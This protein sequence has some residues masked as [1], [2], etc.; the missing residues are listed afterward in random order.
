MHAICR[1][2]TRRGHEV[3][4]VCIGPGRPGD[5]QGV[6]VHVC[7][8]SSRQRRLYE[9]ADVVLTHLERTRDA[10][11]LSQAA[12]KP[13]V[14]VVHNDTQLAAHHVRPEHAD[15]VVF[16]SRWVQEAASWPGRQM[17]LYPP[18]S[19]DE[20]RATPGDAITLINLT[21][22]KGA[23]L[24]YELAQ[25]MPDRRFIGV[26]GG[27]GR[28]IV[29]DILPPNVTILPNTPDIRS[30]YQRTRI[31]LMPSSYESWGR[32]AIEAAASGI[33][34]VANPTPG[35][36]E[37]LG[38][39]GLFADRGDPEAWVAILRSME[40]PEIY[41]RQ[42]ELVRARCRELDP[43]T[44]LDELEQALLSLPGQPESPMRVD[45]VASQRHYVDHLAPIWSALPEH[46]RGAFLVQ[47]DVAGHAQTRS[48][49][50][51]EFRNDVELLALL[52]R[53]SGPVVTAGYGDLKLADRSRRPQVFT[54]HGAGQ[55]YLPF[56]HPAYA[57]GTDARGRLQLYLAPNDYAET[58]HRMRHPG[59]PVE[60]IGCPKLD[61]WHKHARKPVG[62]PVVA[63]SFHWDCQVV[64]ETRTAWPHFRSALPELARRYQ[65]LGH[66]H[67]RIIEQLAPEYRRLGIEV[68]HDFEEVLERA[69]I[70]VCDNSSTLFE[71]AATGRPVVLLNAPWYRRDVHHGLRFWDAAE[72]GVQCDHP[73]TLPDAVEEAIRD[74][75]DRRRLREEVVARVYPV[76][77]GTA[78]GRAAR[79]LL[80]AMNRIRAHRKAPAPMEMHEQEVKVLREMTAIKS[81]AGTVEL[82]SGDGWIEHT[83]MVRKGTPFRV[84]DAKAQVYEKTSLAKPRF[85]GPSEIKPPGPSETKGQEQPGA[86]GEPPGSGGKPGASPDENSNHLGG[87]PT[88][89]T[90]SEDDWPKHTGGGYY[91]LSNGKKVKGKEEGLAAQAALR[92]GSGGTQ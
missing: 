50:P 10:A 9:W 83:G 43:T 1:D 36:R 67:P 12:G 52:R 20:Y 45:F 53:G 44:Q 77:D 71:F 85:P 76:R 11:R 42:S 22:Q 81:F 59:I 92:G 65:V 86:Q 6:M 2:M 13:L 5:F 90:T 80:G 37:A 33:P 4:V 69:D 19:A 48:V 34:T 87:D 49:A 39:S 74:S 41:D 91:L 30:V 57:G 61:A 68:V 75:A 72:I 40:T 79:A 15:L 7:P 21:E 88:G 73:D 16:N 23:P 18:V 82:P 54:E 17:V 58:L 35:L 27:Y 78:S 55:S 66:G 70:Y 89:N 46:A 32:V 63:I 31:L 29:P 84:S 60:V 14:H 38:Q 3:Q 28:Q 26:L 47:A 62:P 8:P 51:I 64:P 25:R 56:T 24:F